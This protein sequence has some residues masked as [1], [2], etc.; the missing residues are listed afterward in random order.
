MLPERTGRQVR[1]R[2]ERREFGPHLK[3][4]RRRDEFLHLFAS[5]DVCRREVAFGMTVLASLGSRDVDN[6][7]NDELVFCGDSTSDSFSHQV[8]R[9]SFK[10]LLGIRSRILTGC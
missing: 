4:V 2:S 8:P 10:Y 3:V 9:V 7:G 5:K 1:C 6:L